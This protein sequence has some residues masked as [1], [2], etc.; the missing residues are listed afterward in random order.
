MTNLTELKKKVLGLI[1]DL[2]DLGRPCEPLWSVIA[3]IN[4]MIDKEGTSVCGK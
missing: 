2:E 4:E 3:W 1:D